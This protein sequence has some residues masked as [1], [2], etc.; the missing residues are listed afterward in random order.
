MT[1]AIPQIECAL[2]R[3]S[4]PE[5]CVMA[6]EPVPSPTPAPAPTPP[7]KTD[8]PADDSGGHAPTPPKQS[9]G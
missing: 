9:G 6:D 3:P 5:I 4:I 8:P 1:D 2:A 7:V